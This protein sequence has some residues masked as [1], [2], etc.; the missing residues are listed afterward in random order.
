MYNVYSFSPSY[1][2]GFS[3]PTLPKSC[4]SNA[5]KRSKV[6]FFALLNPDLLAEG[7]NITA[8]DDTLQINA[9]GA[10]GWGEFLAG[11]NK[12]LDPLDLELSRIRNEETGKDVYALVSVPSP[13]NPLN[14]WLNMDNDPR[15]IARMTKLRVSPVTI[16][17]LRYPTSEHWYI[18]ATFRGSTR[19]RTPSALLPG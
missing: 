9:N 12:S 10:A 11:V 15:S 17:R 8:T 16:R 7:G 3:Q 14:S 1:L 4:G 18:H 13:N 6:S 5:S 2:A 19:S